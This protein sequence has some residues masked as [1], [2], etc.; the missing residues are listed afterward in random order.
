M[1][2]E[3]IRKTDEESRREFLR[4]AGLMAGGAVLLGGNANAQGQ[5]PA[6]KQAGVKPTRFR[7]SAPTKEHQ[8]QLGPLKELGGTWVGHG[9]NVIALPDF[10]D[11]KV[12]RVKLSST[13]ENIQFTQIGGPVPNRGSSGQL[14]INLFG[15]TYLQ[16]VSDTL[17][18]SALH[19]EPGLWLNVPASDVPAQGATVVRQGSIP[20]GTSILAQ[21]A[22][23]PT[24]SNTP[25]NIVVADMTPF[26]D[27]GVRVTTGSP[28]L[29]PFVQAQKGT[30][31]PGIDPA[32]VLDPN[33][34]LSDFL[35]KQVAA[36]K[37]ITRMDVLDITTATDASQPLRSDGVLNIPFLNG[38]AKVTLLTAT[39]W[40]ETVSPADSDPFMQLQYT[41]TTIL[42]FAGLNWPHVSV[43]TLTK[44]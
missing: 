28:Y 27:K 19:I 30:L 24:L 7:A 10:Q 9:L 3:P 17:N 36:G 42:N 31:P 29:D 14:D 23:I 33:R 35:A 21:G 38:N 6:T 13:D 32:Y 15:V 40:I 39:F 4:G 2:R 8:D 34:Y 43:A 26:D 44:Q 16:R 25:P 37:P 12:F 41:Q 1:M 5:T 18:G 22:V 11:G 20:H